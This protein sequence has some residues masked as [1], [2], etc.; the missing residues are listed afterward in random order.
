MFQLSGC[1]C[2]AFDLI[3]RAQK[4]CPSTIMLHTEA[5]KPQ[6]GNRSYGPNTYQMA[7]RALP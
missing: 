2:R 3:P 4:K 1:Y 5:S 6:H 7:T